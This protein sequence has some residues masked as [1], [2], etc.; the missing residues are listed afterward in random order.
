[1]KAWFLRFPLREQ[2]ALLV[3]ALVLVAYLALFLLVKPLADSRRELR[4]RNQAYV[5]KLVRVDSMAAELAAL[6]ARGGPTQGSR[7]RN[8]TNLLNRS[9]ERFDLQIN[10]LQPNSR[11]AVQLRFEGVALDNLLRWIHSVETQESLIVEELSFS[12]TATAG[13]VS[14][15]L[16]IAAGG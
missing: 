11:G 14:A 9:A 10:R 15:N 3:L 13:F 5:S 2:I 4:E 16:R 12:Q 7:Q 6:R 8:L 1:M